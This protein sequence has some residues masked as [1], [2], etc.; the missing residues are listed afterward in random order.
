MKTLTA[1][2]TAKLIA[3]AIAM[4]VTSPV[5]AQQKKVAIAGWGPHPTLDESVA[6]FEKG[7][8]DED[9]SKARTWCSTRPM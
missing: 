4:A 9:S 3:L 1:N 8:A 2:W 5:A 6:G 7:L